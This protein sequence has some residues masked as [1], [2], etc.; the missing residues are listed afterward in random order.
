MEDCN[1]TEKA[2]GWLLVCLGGDGETKRE[3]LA[4]ANP[5]I[6]SRWQLKF[7]FAI[8]P[9]RL[10]LCYARKNSGRR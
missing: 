3:S 7:L 2:R 4:V 5:K 1:K 10:L 8:P 9:Q 6:T